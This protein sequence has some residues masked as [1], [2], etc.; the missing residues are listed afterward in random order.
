MS[1]NRTLFAGQTSN[2]GTSDSETYHFFHMERLLKTK[3][4]L[5]VQPLVLKLRYSETYI[6]EDI[7]LSWYSCEQTNTQKARVLQIN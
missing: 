6:D 4:F 2:F 5:L 1:Q 3:N 7:L